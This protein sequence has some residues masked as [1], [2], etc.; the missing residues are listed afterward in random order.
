MEERKP[1]E[2]DVAELSRRWEAV[3]EAMRAIAS[4]LDVPRNRMGN[5]SSDPYKQAAVQGLAVRYKV[6]GSVDIAEQCMKV[7]RAVLKDVGE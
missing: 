2:E 4:A 1:V 3:T 7:A 6:G 5:L